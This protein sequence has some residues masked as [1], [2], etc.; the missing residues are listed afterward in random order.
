V[1]RR[2]HIWLWGVV[3][4]LED[5]LY[6]WKTST[7]PTWAIERYNL[8]DH[9]EDELDEIIY[10]QWIR[11]HDEKIG[12]LQSEMITVQR[13]IHKLKSELEQCMKN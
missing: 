4:E 1:I 5:I 12:R 9:H 3:C 10:K 6:P 11:A 13:E 2:F 8:P 7:P